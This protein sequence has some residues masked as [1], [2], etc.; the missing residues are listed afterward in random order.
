MLCCRYQLNDD[1]NIFSDKKK[2]I[3]AQAYFQTFRLFALQYEPHPKERGC[4]RK[5][6]GLHMY[7]HA[8]FKLLSTHPLHRTQSY[9]I[10]VNTSNEMEN[11]LTRMSLKSYPY[12]LLIL[13][14]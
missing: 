3:K 5:S 1:S 2:K 13:P 8:V 10:I 12:H 7:S 6:E 4:Q 9:F 14:I 11:N